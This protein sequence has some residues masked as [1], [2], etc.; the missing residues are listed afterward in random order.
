MDPLAQSPSSSQIRGPF[1]A[2]GNSS[3]QHTGRP[4]EQEA[5]AELMLNSMSVTV[6]NDAQYGG[7]I[8][9]YSQFRKQVGS[10]SKS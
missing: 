4:T 10:F 2:S 6:Q 9:L 3:F 8:K 1:K 5:V 7:N